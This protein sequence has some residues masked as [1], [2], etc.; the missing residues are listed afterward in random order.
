MLLNKRLTIVDRTVTW[1]YPT[2][3]AYYRDASSVDAI[4]G[5]RVPFFAIHAEDDPV[6]LSFRY[7][8]CK[9]S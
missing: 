5:I 4:L 6:R 8:P 1:G 9:W 7:N 2:E 3:T